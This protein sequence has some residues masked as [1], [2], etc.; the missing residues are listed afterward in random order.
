MLNPHSDG[1]CWLLT[2]DRQ[3]IGRFVRLGRTRKGEMSGQC[4]DALRGEIHPSH[5][6]RM[7]N[8]FVRVETFNV[9]FTHFV[10][11]LFHVLFLQH[12]DHIDA[13]VRFEEGNR[14]RR[15]VDLKIF[16]IIRR[17][18]QECGS[19]VTGV[20]RRHTHDMP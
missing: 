17:G 18:I 5:G 8:L 12:T 19:P 6:S 2:V 1:A 16:D 20:G 14:E 9:H 7:Q 10:S 11:G 15:I 3:G 13:M 4:H